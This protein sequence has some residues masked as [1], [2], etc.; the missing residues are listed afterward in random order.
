LGIGRPEKVAQTAS[1]SHLTRWRGPTP[2]AMS[3]AS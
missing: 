1:L 2:D 3:S